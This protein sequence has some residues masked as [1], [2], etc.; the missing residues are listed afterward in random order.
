MGAALS[1]RLERLPLSL[2]CAQSGLLLVAKRVVKSTSGLPHCRLL[3]HVD[4]TVNSLLLQHQLALRYALLNGRFSQGR[5][6]SFV[7]SLE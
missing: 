6:F 1:L 4:G 3:V 2:I 5:P 7:Y